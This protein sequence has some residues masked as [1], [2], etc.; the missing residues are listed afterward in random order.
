LETYARD[1]RDISEID[2]AVNWVDRQSAVGSTDINRALLEAAAIVDPE[3]PTYLIFLTDGLPTE[4]VVENTQ[5]LN[6][7]AASAPKSLRLFAFGVGYDVDTF[8]LDS[9]AQEHHGAST[10]VIPGESLDEVLSSFYAKVS[11]PVLMGLQLDFGDLAAYDLY[12]NPLPDLFAGSQIVVVGRYRGGGFTDITLTGSLD[13]NTQTFNFPGQQFTDEPQDSENLSFIPRL[14][15]TRK[16]GYLLNQIRLN[17]PDQELIDQIVRLSIRFGIVTP[18]TS[19]L[20]SESLPL[21]TDQQDRIAEETFNEMKSAPA[22]PS[23]GQDAVEQAAGEGALR[24]ADQV[25]APPAEADNHIQI[26]GA[27]TFVYADGTWVDTA[28]EPDKMQVIQVAFL[29]DDYFAL[30]AADSQLAAA[31]ALGPSVIVLSNGNAYQVVPADS[32]VTATEIPEKQI[33][34]TTTELQPEIT[35]TPNADISTPQAEPNSSSSAIGSLCGGSMIL[36]IAIFPLLG[37]LS[38]RI[39]KKNKITR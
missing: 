18:Y 35:L 14:W 28:F 24:D 12:P 34:Q 7:F 30:V 19:Y 17:G 36:P 13:D 16:I 20:V 33:P 31:F 2:Q 11:T 10:Y 21:G 25:T 3:R 27:R 6:N 15:A 8:L 39:C 26:V 32:T 5:I 4:G 23:F 29:S 1:L 38:L 9:L 22:A 37:L